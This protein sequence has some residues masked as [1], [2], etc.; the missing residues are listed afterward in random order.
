MVKKARGHNKVIFL[1][2]HWHIIVS[3]QKSLFPVSTIKPI[4]QMVAPWRTTYITLH[5]YDASKKIVLDAQMMVIREN[6]H[7]NSDA[8]ELVLP[9]SRVILSFWIL[10][11][12]PWRWTWNAFFWPKWSLNAIFLLH[13]WSKNESEDLRHLF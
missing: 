2:S 10:F 1:Q 4:R 12:I 3:V 11:F 6:L 5:N 7:E 8:C 13:L 9:Y